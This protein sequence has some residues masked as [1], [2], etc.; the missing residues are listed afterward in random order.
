[1]AKIIFWSQWASTPQSGVAA[2]LPDDEVVRITDENDMSPAADAEIAFCGTSS[3]RSRR[4]ITA[5]RK[6]RWFHTPSAGVDRLILAFPKES[7][8]EMVRRVSG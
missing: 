2:A 7:A 5:A 3:D 8:R 6:L 4:L 1:M